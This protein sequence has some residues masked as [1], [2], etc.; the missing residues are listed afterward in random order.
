MGLW[1]VSACDPVGAGGGLPVDA[2]PPPALTLSALGALEPGGQIAFEVAGAQPGQQVGIAVNAWTYRSGSFC[3]WQIAPTCLTLDPAQGIWLVGTAVAGSDGVARRTVRLPRS[4]GLG[5]HGFQAVELMP[6]G[7]I[8]NT[9]VRVVH[10]ASGLR[11][12]FSSWRGFF[13]PGEVVPSSGTQTVQFTLDATNYPNGAGGPPDPV[14]I[15]ATDVVFS[16]PAAAPPCPDCEFVFQAETAPGFV[17]QTWGYGDC[18]SDLGG[19]GTAAL[20]AFFPAGGFQGLS[21]P[22]IWAF[23]AGHTLP[24]GRTADVMLAWDGGAW[25]TLWGGAYQPAGIYPEANLSWVGAYWDQV[26]Y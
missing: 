26:A 12:V 3:P 22:T 20:D 10:A 4:L 25:Q 13:G 8:S 16:S 21:G 2:A 15:A 24:D 17:E 23:D 7:G 14:C 9:L 19:G 5:Y 1:A 11:T 6:G 18:R